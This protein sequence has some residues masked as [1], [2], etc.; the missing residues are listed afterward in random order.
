MK[1]W[2]GFSGFFKFNSEALGEFIAGMVTWVGIS[3][4]IVSILFRVVEGHWPWKSN[5]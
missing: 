2:E 1:F 3:A 4:L 5:R